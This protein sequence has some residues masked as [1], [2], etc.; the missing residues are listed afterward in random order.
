MKKLTTST[1]R[2]IGGQW[3]RRTISFLAIE[4]LRPTPDRV[5]ETLFNW[6]QFDIQGKHCLDLFAGSGALGLEALSRGATSCLFCEK[7]A[8]QAK[9]LGEQCLHLGKPN[10][11]KMGDSLSLLPQLVPQCFD[12]VFI[13][14]PYALKLWAASCQLLVEHQLISTNSVVYLEADCDW[15]SLGLTGQWQ[16]LKSTKAGTVQGFLAHYR[17][18]ED[19]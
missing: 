17:P 16:C 6:L 19:N 10:T 11:V 2:I 4:G 15:Q 8:A 5:R 3:K 12:I 1:L 18:L 7:H 14:P 9:H 13:D